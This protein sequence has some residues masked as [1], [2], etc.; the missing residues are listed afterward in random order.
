MRVT[1]EFGK[2]KIYT[3]LVYEIHS[4]APKAYEAKQISQILDESPIVN[5]LQLKHWKW[6]SDYYMC[7]LGDVFR[8]ALPSAFLLESETT[9]L[10]N[11]DFKDAHELSND[12]FLIFEALFKMKN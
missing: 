4:E 8:A 3:A 2:S 11:T 12:E 6:I 5:E 9:I 10:L 7:T 1:V